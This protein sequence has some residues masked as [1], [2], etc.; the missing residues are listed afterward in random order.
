MGFESGITRIALGNNG[1][2]ISTRTERLGFMTGTMNG[3]VVHRSFRCALA[4]SVDLAPVFLSQGCDRVTDAPP[5][6]CFEIAH[7]VH[8]EGKSVGHRPFLHFMS[9]VCTDDMGTSAGRTLRDVRFGNGSARA[10]HGF[11]WKT[12]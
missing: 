7:P 6:Q 1:S 10:D 11:F 5:K 4:R 12:V 9:D 3:I 8:E 2:S